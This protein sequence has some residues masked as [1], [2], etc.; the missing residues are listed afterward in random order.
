MH[1]DENGLVFSNEE[2]D[3]VYKIAKSAETTTPKSVVER[4]KQLAKAAMYA[5]RGHRD[6]LSRP[7]SV[8]VEPAD[9]L[10]FTIAT[11]AYGRRKGRKLKV[12]AAL[13][14]QIL[15]ALRREE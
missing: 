8:T 11:E 4:T 7:R 14:E 2:V 13:I 15:K 3:A 6:S 1:D 10:W 12:P 9:Q 5:R